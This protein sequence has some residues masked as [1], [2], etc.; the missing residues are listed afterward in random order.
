M[1]F[2]EG[3]RGRLHYRDRPVAGAV[4]ALA[5]LPGSGQHSGHYHEFARRLNADGIAVWTLDT[6]GQGLSEGD[7]DRPA[8]LADLVA[9]ALGFTEVVRDLVPDLPL[10][11]MGHS[12]GAITALAALGA[13]RPPAPEPGRS[14]T[15]DSAEYPV[16]PVLDAHD[17]AGLVLCGT[18]QRAL[19]G[20]PA[21]AAQ[22]P[23]VL[24]VHG[25]DDRRAPIEAV[26]DWARRHDSVELREYPDA[27]HDLLHERVRGRVAADIVQWTQEIVAGPARRS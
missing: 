18:P 17:L 26:R 22:L 5:L 10:T 20:T 4:A 3:A 13:A 14:A 16:D 7:P 6:A 24:A 19:G 9:D 8:R 21:P 27:G 25:V 23:R 11:L 12:L 1:G 15:P 2:F